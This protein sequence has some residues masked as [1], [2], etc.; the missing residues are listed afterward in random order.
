MNLAGLNSFAADQKMD[1]R[2]KVLKR[3]AVGVNHLQRRPTG[4]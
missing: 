4:G 2:V 3:S 1:N